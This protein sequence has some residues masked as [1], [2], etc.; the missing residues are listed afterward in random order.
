[1]VLVKSSRLLAVIG[2]LLVVASTA[3][4]APAAERLIRLLDQVGQEV[5]PAPQPPVVPRVDV[6]L[7]PDAS[8]YQST[9]WQKGFVPYQKSV[10]PYQKPVIAYKQ[11]CCDQRKITYRKHHLRRRV[12]CDPCLP[13]INMVLQV[14]DRCTCCPID[15]PVCVPG[16]CADLPKVCPRKG[17]FGRSITEFEWCCGYRI[18]VVMK[19]NGDLI[20][21]SYG[22]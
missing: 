19:H 15:V 20:V 6:P 18:K 10:V 5:L 1:M 13:P 7:E 12:C 21:H 22:G 17:L 11:P 9:I 16:C 4:S 3:A 14:T 8:P 2:A